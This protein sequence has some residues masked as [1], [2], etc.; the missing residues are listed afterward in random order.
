MKP[1]V[2]HFGSNVA[3]RSD[4]ANIDLFLHISI[5]CIGN[6]KQF[7]EFNFLVFLFATF[8]ML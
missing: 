2:F 4:I 5:K 1:D 3:L 6:F 7:I 8:K